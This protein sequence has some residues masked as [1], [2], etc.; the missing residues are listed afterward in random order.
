MRPSDPG[1]IVLMLYAHD[2]RRKLPPNR[3]MR[4]TRRPS[5][6]L[7]FLANRSGPARNPGYVAAL[8]A[9]LCLTLYGC[10]GDED[11]GGGRGELLEVNGSLKELVWNGTSET[12]YGIGE[13]EERVV[14]V[15]P[16]VLTGVEFDGP[17]PDAVA[18][19]QKVDVGDNLALDP[20]TPSKLYLPQPELGHVR[21][22]RAEDPE[23][24][25]QTFDAGVPPERVALDRRSDVLFALS[26]DGSTV[27]RVD[28]AGNDVTAERKFGPGR[29]TRI[30]APGEGSGALW[31]AGP[32]G[33]ALYGGPSLELVGQTSLDAAGLAVSAQDPERAYVTQ[34]GKGRVAAVEPRSGEGLGV[35]DEAEV[36]GAP[37]LVVTDG[38]RVYV[39][40]DDAVEVLASDD[41][42]TVETIELSAFRGRGPL[43]RVEPSALAVGSDRIYLPLSG[44]PY[45]LALDKP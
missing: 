35:V 25:V 43:E 33:V 39:A 26:K 32:G 27:T 16:E 5:E 40:T 20:R 42:S 8:V 18:S 22:V 31:A 13:G 15:D 30:E 7:P 1:S 44:E 37:R 3:A 14:E 12:L 45:V 28:L 41:L 23:D 24:L 21:V 19:T 34:P 9:V 10:A 11:S 36:G 4:P 2:N 29:A 38:V 17:R 6:P